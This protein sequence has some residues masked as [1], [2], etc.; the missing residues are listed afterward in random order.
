LYLLALY[1]HMIA[2]QGFIW[3][4]NFID[5]WGVEVGEVKFCSY[6]LVDL[7]MISDNANQVW[8]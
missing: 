3:G 7:K 8:N 2:V 5:P 6:Y 1:E 4:I